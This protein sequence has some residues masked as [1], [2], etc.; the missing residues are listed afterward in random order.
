MTALRQPPRL[1]ARS[2]TITTSDRDESRLH[3]VQR[4]RSGVTPERGHAVIDHVGGRICALMRNHR[5]VKA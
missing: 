1:G 3:L 5:L 2:P 4:R